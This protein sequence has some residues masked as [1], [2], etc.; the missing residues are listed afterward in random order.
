[1]REI[2]LIP[3]WYRDYG[4]HIPYQCDDTNKKSQISADDYSPLPLKRFTGAFAVLL[5]G[6]GTAFL[7]LIVQIIYFRITAKWKT[8]TTPII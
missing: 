5:I 3:K 7:I 1:M 8:T 6:Y 4:P 2:G